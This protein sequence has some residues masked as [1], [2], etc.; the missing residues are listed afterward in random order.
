MSGLEKSKERLPS[1]EKFNSLLTD[2]KI[3]K[4]TMRIAV[5]YRIYL[6]CKQ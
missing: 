1:K 5:K 3:V 6:K 4:K 2:K